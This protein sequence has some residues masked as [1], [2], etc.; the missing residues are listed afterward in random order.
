M[1]KCALDLQLALRRA[2][3]PVDLVGEERQDGEVGL[4]EADIE[5]DTLVVIE[6]FFLIGKERS[7]RHDTLG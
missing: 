7:E 3:R 1:G 4:V 2:E 6:L 5:L